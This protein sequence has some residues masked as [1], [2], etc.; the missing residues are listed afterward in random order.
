MA[1]GFDRERWQDSVNAAE[2]VRCLS[3]AQSRGLCLGLTINPLALAFVLQ[4]GGELGVL[5]ESDESRFFR[6]QTSQS[7]DSLRSVLRAKGLM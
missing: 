2:V 1:E 4:R 7:L 3:I 6:L 5:P